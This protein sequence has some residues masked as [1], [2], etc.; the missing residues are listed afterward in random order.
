MLDFNNSLS[1]IPIIESIGNYIYS[2]FYTFGELF[3]FPNSQPLS[4]FTCKFLSPINGA[5]IS[6]SFGD[7]KWVADIID[8]LL[9]IFSYVP[10]LIVDNLG[11]EQTVGLQIIASL[12]S[13]V[14]AFFILKII[15]GFFPN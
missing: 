15:I 8:G 5:S 9:D 10:M 4:T 12:I 14:L 1:F 7:N 2:F 13:L 11:I 3:L 6:F